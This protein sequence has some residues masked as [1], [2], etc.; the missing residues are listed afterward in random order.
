[1]EKTIKCS[2]CN[3]VNVDDGYLWTA[4]MGAFGVK[5]FT[6]NMKGLLKIAAEK[7]DAI[8]CLDCGNIDLRVEPSK[9]RN[10]TKKSN[11]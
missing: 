10:I 11:Q 1:M 3:S 7:I 9:L 2:K 4:G 6:N 5:Y 8:A